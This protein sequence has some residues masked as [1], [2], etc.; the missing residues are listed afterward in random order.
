[1]DAVMDYAEAAT[2]TALRTIPSG[3]YSFEDCL[4]DDGV[5]EGPVPLRVRLT[6]AEGAI[7]ADFAGSAPECL[8]SVNAVLAVTQ[9]ATYYIVRCLGGDDIPVNDGCFRPVTVIAPVGSVLN[10]RPPRAVVAGNVETSQRVTDI[11]LGALAQALPNRI[12]A[13]S[14]GTMSNL[15]IGGHDPERGRPFAYYETIAGGA[16]AGPHGPGLNAVH[17]HMTNTLNTPVEALEFAYPFRVT[18]YSVREGSGG[19]GR[20]HGGDGVRRSYEFLCPASVTLL[21][22]RRR[23]PPFG[24]QGGAPGATG[25]NTLRP[26]AGGKEPLPGKTT[27]RVAPGDALVIDTPGGGGWGRGAHNERNSP[28]AV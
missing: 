20:H 23:Y 24:V 7:T 16:G 25:R 19:A 5:T 21:T 6:V 8:G 12:P 22:D 4:D 17:A 14:Y 15:T 28:P 2:R 26:A 9:S 11:L 18:E 3:E 1:M 27:R 10:P 13:A